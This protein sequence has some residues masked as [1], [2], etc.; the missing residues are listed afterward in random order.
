MGNHLVAHGDGVRDM[1]FAVDNLDTIVGAVKERGGRII[2][3]PKEERDAG[4]SVR[5]ATVQPVSEKNAIV[6]FKRSQHEDFPV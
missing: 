4:G 5:F 2:S 3:G 6:A 1:A